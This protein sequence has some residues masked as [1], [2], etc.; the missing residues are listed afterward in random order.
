MRLALGDLKI[1]LNRLLEPAN[2]RVDSLTAERIET[3]R[4]AEL[5]QSGHFDKPVYGA[6]RAGLM[7]DTTQLSEKIDAQKAVV[8]KFGRP[9]LNDVAYSFDN[10]YFGSPDTEVLYALMDLYRPKRIVEIGSGNSTR[11]MRQAI[12]D[13]GLDTKIVSIDPQP[14]VEVAHLVDEM[15]RSCIEVLDPEQVAGWLAPGDILFIDSSHLIAVGGDISFLYFHVL[16]RVKAGV[17]IH[18][19]DIFLPYEYPKEW[20]VDLRWRFNEQFL[21]NAILAWSD[22]FSILWPGY[23]LQRADPNFDVLFPHSNGRRAQSFWLR[24]ER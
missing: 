7:L 5:V 4:L 19:H 22:T 9:E 1:F 23:F 6:F 2:V 18:V 3:Q 17:L 10:A 8:E 13:H 12:L 16:P 21:L 15:H 14:R 11:V 20:V 24:K